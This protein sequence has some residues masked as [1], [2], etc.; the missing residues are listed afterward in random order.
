MKKNNLKKEI[1]GNDKEQTLKN[2]K[3][4]TKAM[5]ALDIFGILILGFQIY[6]K[7]ISYASHIIVL[8]C[9]IFV[10]VTYKIYKDR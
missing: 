5:I 7:D 8:I 1:I 10:F 2:L 3:K 4:L 9:N 6:I